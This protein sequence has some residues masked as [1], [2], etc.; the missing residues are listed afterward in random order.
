MHR[1]EELPVPTSVDDPAMAGFRAAVEVRNIVQEAIYGPEIGPVPAEELLPNWSDPYQPKRLFVAVADDRVVARGVLEWPTEGAPDVVYLLNEVLPEYRGRGIGAAVY[2]ALVTGAR[3]LGRTT[4]QGYFAAVETAG[5]RVVPATGVGSV[6]AAD[7]GVRFASARGWTLEQVERGSRLGLPVPDIDEQLARAQA[8]SGDDWRVHTWID[9]APAAFVPDLAELATGMGTDAPSAELE[10]ED[11]WT[12]ERW[13]E[14]E[15]RHVAS[16][17]RSLMAAVEHVPTGRIA[18]FTA[19]DVPADRARAVGQEDTIVGRAY[20]GHRLGMLL[21]VA[22]LAHLQR[23]Y[24][25]YPSV[26]TFNAEENRH[27]LAVNEAV[28]FEPLVYEG[29]WKKVLD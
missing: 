23:E 13:L 15:E 2:D 21:K 28:G 10:A 3:E 12:P 14:E 9:R 16:P 24:P 25:G 7:A 27:M 18:G 5:E 29:A 20:R 26:I 6:P 19:L 1:I 4:L 11:P 22:N 17:R 8:A